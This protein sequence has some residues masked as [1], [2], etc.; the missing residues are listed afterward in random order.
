MFHRGN[1]D[2]IE[3]NSNLKFHIN[4]VL[5]ETTIPGLYFCRWQFIF[6]QI[7]M[8]GSETRV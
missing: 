7:L 2:S 5:L 6:I 1:F 3:I 8:V 4:L